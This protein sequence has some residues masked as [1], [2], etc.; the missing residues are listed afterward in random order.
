MPLVRIDLAAGKPAEYRRAIGDVVYD[1]MRETINVPKD[2]R[3]QIVTEHEPGSLIYDPNYMGIRRR[4]E[5]VFIQ[6]LASNWRDT[7]TK[8][9]LYRRIVE[10]LTERP[11]LR[12]EDV[13]IALAPNDRPDWSFGNGIAQYVKDAA[14]A[15]Q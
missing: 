6:I 15:A 7:A 10:R 14:D 12:S 13:L 8:Q 1:A 5:V 2:D 3:F 11:G 9:K 4:D